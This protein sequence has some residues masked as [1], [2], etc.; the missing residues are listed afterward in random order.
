ME[1]INEHTRTPPPMTRMSALIR[2][3]PK[4]VW[5]APDLYNELH[6]F[7]I[8]V[9]NI[10]LTNSCNKQQRK[11]PIMMNW[12]GCEGLRFVQTLNDIEK[13]GARQMQGCSKH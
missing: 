13:K 3:Q 1:R 6:N 12:I 2:K 11:I 7:E 9:R 5:K 8:E 10:F 4:F